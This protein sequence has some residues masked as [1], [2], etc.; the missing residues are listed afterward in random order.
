MAAASTA[1]TRAGRC[2]GTNPASPARIA[3]VLPHA[4]KHCSVKH[5][6]DA[7]QHGQSS[8]DVLAAVSGMMACA[9]GA[10]AK[11]FANAPDRGRIGKLAASSTAKRRHTIFIGLTTPIEGGSLP[12]LASI[13]ASVRTFGDRFATEIPLTRA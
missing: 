12:I 1:S 7:S 10:T 8:L 9:S 3:A 11:V 4:W 2:G 13:H 6:R 5:F